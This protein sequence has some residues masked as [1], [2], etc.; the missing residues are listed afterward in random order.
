MFYPVF[1]CL[2]Y[3]L[4]SSFVCQ[5]LRVKLLIEFYEILHIK[6]G[7]KYGYGSTIFDGW[8]HLKPSRKIVP[9]AM[10]TA[11]HSLKGSTVL[12]GALRS[13]SALNIIMIIVVIV[14]STIEYSKIGKGR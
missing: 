9:C 3:L 5:Q 14:M 1:V 12:G 8:E 10:H 11:A 4:I 13:P 7:G 6:F 2:N